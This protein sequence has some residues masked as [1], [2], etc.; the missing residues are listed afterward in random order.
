MNL[1]P[2]RGRGHRRAQRGGRAPLARRADAGV[3]GPTSRKRNAA[4]G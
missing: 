2:Y 3:A 4:R 1:R